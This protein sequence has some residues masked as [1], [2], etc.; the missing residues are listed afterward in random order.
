MFSS[1]ALVC[2]K[3]F[4]NRCVAKEGVVTRVRKHNRNL[5]N[6][7]GQYKEAVRTLNN[8]LKEVRGKL[9]EADCQ[10]EKLQQEVTALSERVETVGTDVVQEFKA[11]QSFIDSY[12]EYYG[13]GFDD[14]LKQ[15]A[16]VF[17]ELD[18]S[19]ITMDNESDGSLESNP[20]PKDDGVVVLAHLAANPPPTPAS[21][22][23]TVFVDVENQK[24]DGNPADA[25]AT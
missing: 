14:C 9:E 24:D 20:P 18:L 4:Q 16:S 12:A 25:L 21:N 17:P 8:E 7:Q 11:S 15:V 1:Q 13:T 19:E 10:K 22:S 5:M 2:V 3:A 6:E 23:P